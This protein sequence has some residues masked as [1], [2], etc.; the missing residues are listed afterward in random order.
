MAGAVSDIL[1]DP[2]NSQRVY[3]AFIGI[4]YDFKDLLPQTVFVTTNGGSCWSPAMGTPPYA[5]PATAAHSLAMNPAQP[6]W[7]YAGTDNGVY[8]SEDGGV[9]WEQTPWF[10]THDGPYNVMVRE[11]SWHEPDYLVAS[12]YG[13]GMHRTRV[14]VTIFVDKSYG[15]TEL[16]TVSQPFNT[17]KEAVNLSGH[18]SNL[19]IKGGDYDET[20]VTVLNIRGIIRGIG[21][22]VTIR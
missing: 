10:G 5:L 4:G 2:G 13:L 20:G 9:R 18:G 16:G 11:L 3:V 19:T 6:N 8:V 14:P 15:G 7:I 22:V 12:T 17:V 1:I 21:G